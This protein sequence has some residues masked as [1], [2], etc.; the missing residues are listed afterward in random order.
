M[1]TLIVTILIHLRDLEASIL[2]TWVFDHFAALLERARTD[3]KLREQLAQD[4]IVFFLHLIG[5]DT[6]GHA[7]RPHSK[8]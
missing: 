5:L 4:K 8:E 6:N 7:F 3:D 1:V 2:D